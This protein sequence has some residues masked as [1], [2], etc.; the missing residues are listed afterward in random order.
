MVPLNYKKNIKIP[1]RII[2]KLKE[3]AIPSIFINVNQNKT[4]ETNQYEIVPKTFTGVLKSEQTN[5]LTLFQPTQGNMCRRELSVSEGNNLTQKI[6]NI[7]EVLIK[8]E[9]TLV[10][11]FMA[12][13]HNLQF[14]NIS[15]GWNYFCDEAAI[16]FCFLKYD[17]T[18]DTKVV[19]E[20]QIVFTPDLNINYFINNE[21]LAK[22]KYLFNLAYPF[23]TKDIEKVLNIFSLKVICTGGPS[24]INF[25]GIYYRNGQTNSNQIWHHLQCSTLIEPDRKRCIFCE[26]LLHSF[27]T[28]KYRLN[29][30]QN[31]TKTLT[32]TKKKF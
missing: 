25:P 3:N 26:K 2:P 8:S 4:G 11:S 20:K 10:D 27:R 31:H 30:N 32:P 16:S 18:R 5:G 1:Q 13:K 29:L 6:E 21:L 15:P 14:I 23:Q 19:I 17:N 12:L 9:N 28:K 7:D 24:K 22:D